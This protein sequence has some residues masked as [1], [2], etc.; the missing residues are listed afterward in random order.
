MAYLSPN[1]K[2]SLVFLEGKV[3]N[4]MAEK[5]RIEF[6]QSLRGGEYI[7]THPAR[8]APVASKSIGGTVSNPDQFIVIPKSLQNLKNKPTL[9]LTVV[10]E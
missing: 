3:G 1:T 10:L 5:S 6:T 9:K 4:G 8:P 7:P 2:C